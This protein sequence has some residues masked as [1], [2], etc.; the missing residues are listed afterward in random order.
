MGI[1]C[2]LVF[3]LVL[4]DPLVSSESHNYKIFTFTTVD[5]GIHSFNF[6]VNNASDCLYTEDNTVHIAC[7]RDHS[8]SAVASTWTN[9]GSDLQYVAV[10]CL[11]QDSVRRHSHYCLCKTITSNPYFLCNIESLYM[12]LFNSTTNIKVL[13]LSYNTIHDIGP[14]SFYGLERLKYLSL[15]QNTFTEIPYG[16]FC[17]TPSLEYLDIRDLNLDVFPSHSFKCEDTTSKVKAIDASNSRIKDVPKDSLAPL[18]KLQSLNLGSNMIGGLLSKSFEGAVSLMDLNVSDNT[19]KNLFPDFCKVLPKLRTLYLSTNEFDVFSLEEISDC[20]LLKTLDIS[21]NNISSVT[22]SLSN[23][24]ALKYLNVS[25]NELE[26]FDMDVKDLTNLE[27]LDLSHNH[28]KELDEKKI[29]GLDSLLELHVAYNELNNSDNFP[30]LF[31][32]FEN[33]KML[34]MQANKIEHLPENSFI[35][36]NNLTHLLLNDNK[37]SRLHN[38]T[39]AGLSKLRHLNLDNNEFS[40]LPA[41]ILQPLVS[42]EY[43]SIINNHFHRLSLYF[44]PPTV[45][46]L[47]LNGNQLTGVPET[48]DYSN[49]KILDLSSNRLKTFDIKNMTLPNLERLDLS[50]NELTDVS[51]TMFISMPNLMSLTLARN[52]LTFNISSNSFRD[53]PNL[54]LLDLA[55]NNIEMIEDIFSV[56]SLNSLE[57]LNISNNLV[58]D[59]KQLAVRFTESRIRHIDLSNCNITKLKSDVFKNLLN[60]THVDLSYNNIE[61]FEP[62]DAVAATSYDFTGNPIIC[63]CHIVWLK[64]PYIEIEGVKIPSTKYIVPKCTA[65]TMQG[66]HSPQT[67]RREQYL[68]KEV[69]GCDS[70]CTCFKREKDGDILLTICRKN[71]TVAPDIIPQT[72]RTIFLDGNSFANE[73]L[74]TFSKFINM[75]AREIYLNRSSILSVDPLIFEGFKHIEILSLAGNKLTSI[76]SALFANKT[77]LKQLYLQNNDLSDFDPGTFVGLDSLQE[78][79]ISGNNFK[80]LDAESTAELASLPSIKYF[81]LANNPWRCDCNNKHFKDFVDNVKFKISDRRQLICN[82][83]EMTYV[84]KSAFSCVAYHKP[85]SNYVGKTIIIVIFSIIA[86]VLVCSALLYFRRECVSVLYSATGIHV[87]PRRRYIS[88]KPFDVFV[89][90]DP[91]DQHS[92][93]YVQITLWPKLRKAHYNCQTTGDLIQ[94]IDVTKKAIEDCKCSVFVINNNFATNPFLVKLFH[95][96]TDYCKLGSHKVI[97]LIHGDIDILTLEPE[98]VKR[99]RRGDYITARSRLWWQRLQFELPESTKTQRDEHDNESET[100]TII[101]S[102]IADEGY[103][104]SMAET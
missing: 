90:Y 41:R 2:G 77:T 66:I 34:D 82:G 1:F 35:K 39:F 27:V 23:L 36:L 19:L 70:K 20:T 54:K 32:S 62:F 6:T 48:I 100:D 25:Y 71:L 85:E 16:V 29:T 75:S 55:E 43:I 92:A 8:Y 56:S 42:L 61:T 60:L 79:D 45:E 74:K 95:I 51:G 99:M 88:G 72:A 78:L 84:P 30:Q 53:T 103:Y 69:N 31:A 14:R 68:C 81:F 102:A 52:K 98:I 76:P 26:S 83:Q 49:M 64:E 5:G 101:F 33:L 18:S 63:S 91:T 17:D 9:R 96:A 3:V 4:L 38:N 28:L 12:R 73:S 86:V 40:S 13:D 50:N 57:I 93:E 22:G 94:D 58:A 7:M 104:N 47:Y 59:I 11:Q 15:R 10:N 65:Y 46:F 80:F 44:W 67:V 87:P 37:I 24:T 97:L 21:I 89:S